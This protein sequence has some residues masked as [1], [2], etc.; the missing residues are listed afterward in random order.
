MLTRKNTYSIPYIEYKLKD[1]VLDN[2]NYR[3]KNAIKNGNK[4]T[5]TV[6]IDGEEILVLSDRYKMFFTQGYTCKEC[7]LTGK[8]FALEKADL[9]KRYHLNLYAI[10]NGKEILMTKDHIIPKSKGG[11]NILSNYQTMC[12]VCNKKKGDK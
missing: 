4:F 7:G 9:D 2:L 5:L 6:V 3:K 1:L 8:F 12:T 11:K 10:K